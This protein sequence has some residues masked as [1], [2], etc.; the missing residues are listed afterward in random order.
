MLSVADKKRI[1]DRLSKL[2]SAQHYIAHQ[3]ADYVELLCLV[4][5]DR[6][7]DA[8]D[9]LD[10]VL[11]RVVDLKQGAD[12]LAIE[13]E[14]LS[15]EHAG[16]MATDRG[17]IADIWDTRASEWFK[18]LATRVTRYG[19]DYPFVVRGETI[20]LKRRQTDRQKIY[21]FLLFC[22]SQNILPH[23]S[24]FTSAFEVLSYYAFQGLLP[25]NAKTHMFGSHGMNND[26][27]F[28]KGSLSQKRTRLA[29][30]LNTIVSPLFEEAIEGATDSGDGGIDLVGWIPMGDSLQGSVVIFGQCACTMN[31]ISKQRDCDWPTIS[32]Q[33]VLRAR[34]QN[35]IFIPFCNRQ[36]N[37][38]WVNA[39]K[40]QS[41]MM[42][43]RRILYFTNFPE[44]TKQFKTLTPFL[45]DYLQISERVV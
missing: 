9:V 38:K 19:T 28:A 22:A 11:E 33:F 13:A 17:K 31:W 39:T 25:A 23:P 43:R 37:G 4:N 20:Q 21:I 5:P 15:E 36:H 32:G 2:P 7:L 45:N 18:M 12:D 6:Y 34:T 42:D 8:C 10:R 3:W 44:Y 27:I 26:K 35:V 14:I 16:E 41:V 24:L 40:I 29:E 1:T 30:C